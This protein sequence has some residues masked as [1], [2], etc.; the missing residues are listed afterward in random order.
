[1][2]L[3]QLWRKRAVFSS[4]LKRNLILLHVAGIGLFLAI[5]N[6]PRHFRLCTVAPPA[7]LIFVWLL[8]LPIPALGYIRKLSWVVAGCYLVLLPVSR[9]VQWHDTLDLPI[10]RTAFTDRALLQKFQWVAERTHPSDGFFNDSALTLYLCLHNPTQTAFVTY[11]ETTRPEQIAAVPQA[12]ERDPLAYIALLPVNLGLTVRGDHAA[13]FRRFVY[14]NY[15]LANV[16][17]QKQSQYEQQLWRRSKLS[18]K[19]R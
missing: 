17:S 1:V 12:L 4:R 14:D 13:P 9:Q 11:D 16:F 8:T 5:A 2:G 3:Y 10:G 15:S 7:I 18:S 6:G 19:E